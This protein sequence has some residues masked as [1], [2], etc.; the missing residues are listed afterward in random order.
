MSTVHIRMII[1][2]VLDEN[3]KEVHTR[4][5]IYLPCICTKYVPLLGILKSIF[6]YQ[7]NFHALASIL[8]IEM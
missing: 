1:S 7:F 5:S 8:E 2:Y 6:L 3:L 4:P